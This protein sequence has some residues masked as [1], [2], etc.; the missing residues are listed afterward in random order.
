MDIQ[1]KVNL[2]WLEASVREVYKAQNKVPKVK[3]VVLQ[4]SVD[5]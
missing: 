1:K 3:I 4:T 2:K 5:P